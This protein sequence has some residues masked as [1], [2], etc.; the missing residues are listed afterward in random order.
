MY[1]LL[2]KNNIFTFI[3][4][5]ILLALF[6]LC[7]YLFLNNDFKKKPLISIESIEYDIYKFEEF[8]SESVNSLLRS[9]PDKSSSILE[10][11]ISNPVVGNSVEKARANGSQT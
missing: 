3:I 6:I 9:T 1:T 10:A 4:I 2:K 11:S 5:F 8:N 7:F